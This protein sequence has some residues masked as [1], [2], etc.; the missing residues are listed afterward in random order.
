MQEMFVVDHTLTLITLPHAAFLWLPCREFDFRL[1]A[2]SLVV[3]L[4]SFG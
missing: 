2:P 3:L 4:R 1:Q